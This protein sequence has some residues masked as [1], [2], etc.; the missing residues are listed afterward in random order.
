MESQP[1]TRPLS[2]LLATAVA[3]AAAS[4][5]GQFRRGVR[6]VSVLVDAADDDLRVQAGGAQ[7]GEP[8]GGSGSENDTHA[9][10]L[11][12]GRPGP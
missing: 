7:H 1:I 6:R 2:R 9:S 10:D 3:L 11:T 8:G 4:S 12:L 5:A